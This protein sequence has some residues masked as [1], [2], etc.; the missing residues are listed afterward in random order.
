[1]IRGHR[2]PDR[3]VSCGFLAI[4]SFSH[5]TKKAILHCT[6]ELEHVR[7]PLTLSHRYLVALCGIKLD[8]PVGPVGVMSS[9]LSRPELV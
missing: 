9:G 3:D 7:S 8:D 4:V 1:M 6:H 5:P 2:T